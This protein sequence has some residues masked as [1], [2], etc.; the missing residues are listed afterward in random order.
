M[1]NIRNQKTSIL[2][3]KS[4]FEALFLISPLALMLVSI[5]NFVDTKWLLSRLIPL[6]CVYCLILYR[7]AM[8]RN[9]QSSLIRPLLLASL[10]AFVYFAL[11]HLVRGDEF[12][13]S[14]TLLACLVYLALIPWSRVSHRLVKWLVVIAAVACGINAGYEYFVMGVLRVGIATNPIPYALYCALLALTSLSFMLS[15]KGHIRFIASLGFVSA[16]AAL[17]LTD[18]R[19]VLLFF[20]LI[21]LYLALRILPESRSYYFITLLLTL[22]SLAGGYYLFQDKIDHRIQ[23]TAKELQYISDGNYRTSIGIRLNLWQEGLDV[24]EEHPVFG[25]GDVELKARIIAMP[26]SKAAIQPHLHNQYIDTLSRYGTV[27]FVI[28]LLWL[29]SPLVTCKPGGG[30]EL[31]LDPLLTSLILMVALAGMTDV[32]FHHTHVVYLFTIMSGVLLLTQTPLDE[33]DDLT[34]KPLA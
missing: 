33:D 15:E 30:V 25:V 5:F 14:R 23:Q 16:V 11:V 4:N 31:R 24:V 26:N 32:P 13:F 17:V 12:G 2:E 9:W 22:F 3:F 1:T 10:L 28:L 34:V 27:G 21:A 8:K 6:V 29:V 7:G 18:V 20:P 19:G